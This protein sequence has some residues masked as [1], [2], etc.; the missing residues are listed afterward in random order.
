MSR[1]EPV[2]ERLRADILSGRLTPGERLLEITLADA[3]AC[4]RASVRSAIMQLSAEGLVDREANR[5]ATVRRI[6]ID[7][8][9]Q[10]T[11]ARAALETLI[12]ARAAEAATGEER[13]ELAGI[14]AGMRAAVAQDRDRDYSDLNEL[15]HRRLCEVSGHKVAGDLVDKLRNRAAHHQYR[16]AMIPG[17]SSQSLPEHEAI[18]DAVL[19]GDADAARAAMAA[20]LDSVIQALRRWSDAPFMV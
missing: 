16:L 2:I 20:H 10:I 8:A 13:Q 12:A 14:I 1:I 15:L 9:I 3:Y 7:E 17:R 4:S 11:E 5:G 6:S 18:V 19:A